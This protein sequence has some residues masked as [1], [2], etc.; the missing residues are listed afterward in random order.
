MERWVCEFKKSQLKLRLRNRMNVPDIGPGDR[1]QMR[2]PHPCGSDQWVI[3][4]LGADIGMRCAGCDRTVMLARGVFNKRL[5]R[6]V[7]RAQDS[8]T[9]LAQ[10]GT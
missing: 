7:Q 9:G 3:T 6:V 10:P 4:R 2:K 8:E 1:V 5:K